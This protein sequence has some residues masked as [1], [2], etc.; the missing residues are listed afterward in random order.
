MTHFI[1]HK[2]FAT[3]LDSK[4][5]KMVYPKDVKGNVDQ[6]T[7]CNFVHIIRTHKLP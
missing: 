7:L 2:Y 1:G 3:A 6:I 4:L 5:W